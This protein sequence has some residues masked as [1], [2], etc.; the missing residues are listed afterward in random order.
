MYQC[1]EHWVQ[2]TNSLPDGNGVVSKWIQ[3]IMDDIVP[4]TS[5][6]KVLRFSHIALQ[7]P[8][9]LTLMKLLCCVLINAITSN[10]SVAAINSFWKYTDV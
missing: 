4:L 2:L 10:V 3:Q 9:H 1:L 8:I 7:I 6:T 5:Q